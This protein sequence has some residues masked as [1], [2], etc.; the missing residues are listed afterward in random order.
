MK[1][2]S[3]L[4]GCALALALVAPPPPATPA[5]EFARITPTQAP[6]GWGVQLRTD[7]AYYQPGDVAKVEHTLMNAT[8]DDAFGVVPIRGG[9]GCTYVI[10]IEDAAGRILWE[11]G[12]I[13]NGV[14]SGPGCFFGSS[15]IDL[16]AGNELVREDRIEL[17]HQNRE[18]HGTLGEPLPPGVYTVRV[19]ALF[20]GPQR[21][22]N[23]MSGL[24][25]EAAVPIRIE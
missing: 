22:V 5:Q 2:F 3:A 11:P 17:I 1:L 10:T 14:F 9:N 4:S 6:R 18:G 13:V 16:S 24:N 8:P 19:L 20:L 12:S 15:L 23:G 25:F 21:D 7:R